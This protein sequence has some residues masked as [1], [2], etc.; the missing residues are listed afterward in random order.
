MKN[1][2][3]HMAAVSALISIF[4]FAGCSRKGGV[5]ETVSV[6]PEKQSMAVGT[7]LRFTAYG[8]FT[9]GTKLYWSEVVTW[10]SS[11]PNIA[12]VSN[13]PGS[14]GLVTAVA[15][16]ENVTITAYD[17]ANNISGSAT[18]EVTD[19]ASL[20]I[21]PYNPFIPKNGYNLRLS[22]IGTFKDFTT[23]DVSSAVSWT[24]SDPEVATFS[25]AEGLKNV[26]TSN[27]TNIG[28]TTITATYVSIITGITSTISTTVLTVMD[29]PLAFLVIEPIEPTIKTNETTITQL[30]AKGIFRDISTGITSTE[31]MTNSVSWYS[32]NE[33]VAI[34]SN[35]VATAVTPG[36]TTIRAIDPVTFINISTMLTVTPS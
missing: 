1:F 35:G 11:D 12:T 17:A 28:T 30:N 19:P 14:N 21:T 7:K 36:T 33:N 26:I 24:S 3:F 20:A 9:S 15:Y 6:T 10:S 25:D 16:G 29:G 5:L 23:A 8:I 27:I 18:L 4:V 13:D 32:S 31:P 34:I 22:A 2:T